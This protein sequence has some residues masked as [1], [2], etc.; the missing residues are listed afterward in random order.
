MKSLIEKLNED[1]LTQNLKPRLKSGKLYVSAVSRCLANPFYIGK[2]LWKGQMIQGSHEPIISIELWQ[3]VQEVLAGRN[4]NM[5]KEHNV[6]PFAYKGMFTCGVCGRAVTA[7]TAKGKYVYYHCTQYKTNCGQ[8]WVKEE[9]LDERFEKVTKL[10]KISDAGMAFVTTGLK[11]SLSEKREWSDKAFDTLV[12]EQD[13]L[14]KRMDAMYEDRLDKK[15]TDHDYERR[16]TDY[17]E[18]LQ[19]IEQ[20]IEKHNKADVNYYEFG[21]RIL[22]L[23]ENAEKLLKVAKPEEKRELTKFLLSNSKIKDGEPVFELK[24]PFKSIAKHAPLGTCS[25]WQGYV[26]LMRTKV[27]ARTT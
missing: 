19:Q 1:G 13:C 2:F 8:P 6:I 20:R 25:A 16:F 23:A 11:K 17:T 7:E 15:I 9:T 26:D 24:L 21:H 4:Q 18:Q 14:R 27:Y 5:S 12:E 10:L 3:K 22:E